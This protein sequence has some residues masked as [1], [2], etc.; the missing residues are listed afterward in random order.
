MAI[1]DDFSVAVNGDIR[2]VSGTT[3]YTVLEFHRWLQ[4]LADQAQASGN[5]L[6]DI[7]SSTPSARATDNII[8]LNSPYN[9]DDTA[10]Q[11][12]Y[13]GSIE[14]SGGDTLYSGLVVV[15]SVYG[16]TTLQVVQN[17]ALYNTD[18]PFWGTGI[19]T[20]AAN[21]ILCRMLIKTRDTGTDIDGKRIL[22]Y[23]REWGHSYAEFSVTMGLGNS[24]AAIFTTQDLN[25]QTVVGTVATWT[26]ISNT[27]GYQTID[28]LNGD[29]AQPYYSQWNKDI[30]SINQLYERAKWLTRRG[31]SSTVYGVDGELFRGI[32]HQWGYDGETG[33]GAWTQNEELT[34]G[35]GATAGK[36]I[37]IAVN[38]LGTTGTIWIQLKSG[39][40]PTDDVVVTGGSSAK[41]AAV[42]GSV[43]SR[44]ISPVFL[45]QS[46]GSAIIGGFGVGIEAAD[47]TQN[48]K[49]FDLTNTLRT[50]PNNQQFIVYGLVSGEDR[51]L[52][53][54]ASGGGIDFDQML[55][56]T[57]LDDVAEV[58][59]DVG[60]AN[61]PADTPQTGNLRIQ[62]VSGIYRLVP[63][64][65]HDGNRYF[66]IASTDFS[67]DHAPVG[68][69]VFLGYI[70]KLAT[71]SQESVTLKYASNRTMFVRVRD[72][73]ISSEGPIKTYETTALFGTG[74]GSATASRIADE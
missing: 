41:T 25:N 54:N 48:D 4:D 42:N 39:V 50:P 21:N 43:T 32:T 51:V 69:N 70:D 2:H 35:T 67:G 57:E 53:T 6:L 31:T 30:Y 18:S 64:T 44:S 13:N 11:Y 15:G 1:G 10:A 66:T 63:Y 24:V 17:F 26:T 22:V 8:T 9:I 46:T 65:A 47:L 20:D 71:S 58:Q 34:W 27:E 5:D 74:G 7:T 45:G 68:Q 61:I 33:G 23:A 29:G 49:V 14:Q 36:G 56:A 73:E 55:I 28:L 62:L 19:N 12:L 60:A 37:L 16:T 40:P 52:V 72:G 3:R 59:V 38:D